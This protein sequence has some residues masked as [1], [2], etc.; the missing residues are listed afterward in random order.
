MDEKQLQSLA[1]LADISGECL[2]TLSAISKAYRS[3]SYPHPSI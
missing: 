1:F 2:T 3:G